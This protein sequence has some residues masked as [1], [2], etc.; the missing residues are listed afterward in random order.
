MFLEAGVDAVDDLALLRL[1]VRLRAHLIENQ[2]AAAGVVELIELAGGNVDSVML[3]DCVLLT[4]FESL[5]SA[6]PLDDE[7]RVVRAGM[8]VHLVVDAG[9]VAVER[10]VAALRTR[11]ADIVPPI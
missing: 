11:D 7:K 10:D 9:L 8:A 5:N 6:R 4:V 3:L 1:R 2:P